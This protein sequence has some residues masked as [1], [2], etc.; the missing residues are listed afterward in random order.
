MTA[1]L[2]LQKYY[3]F[4]DIHFHKQRIII[5]WLH[6]HVKQY[7]RFSLASLPS[8]MYVYLLYIA[9]TNTLT[10]FYDLNDKLMKTGHYDIRKVFLKGYGITSYILNLWCNAVCDDY[11]SRKTLKRGLKPYAWSTLEAVTDS[12]SFCSNVHL[13]LAENTPKNSIVEK[14]CTR[15]WPRNW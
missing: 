15:W 10:E 3:H 4:S 9:A 13:S 5:L 6:Y 7:R 8:H 11:C 14:M 12:M 2:E 1:L